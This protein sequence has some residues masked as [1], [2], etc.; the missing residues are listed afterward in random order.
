M[1]RS[2][3]LPAAKRPARQA[4]EER[5]LSYIDAVREATNQEMARDPSVILFGLDVDDPKAIQGIQAAMLG[6]PIHFLTASEIAYARRQKP[7]DPDRAWQL[8]KQR[9]MKG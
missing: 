9:A 5:T 3:S 1:I 6:G 7:K 4:V 2:L 8:W